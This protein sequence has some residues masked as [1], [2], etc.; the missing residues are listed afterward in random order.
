MA[1][2]NSAVNHNGKLRELLGASRPADDDNENFFDLSETAFNCLHENIAECKYF[3]FPFF[4]TPDFIDCDQKTLSLFR[5]NIRSLNKLDNF[6]NF[7]EFLTTLPFFPDIVCVS[8][9]RLKG[10]PLINVSIPGY[11]FLHSDS[12]TNAG[13]V[14]IYV[15]SKFQFT[16]DHELNLNVNGCEDIWLNVCLGNNTEKKITIGAVYR[17]PNTSTRN[18]EEISQALSNVM[19][20]I[21]MR[22]DVFYLLGDLNIDI[23]P[24]KVTPG[25]SIYIDSLNSFGSVPIV[26][27]R[28]RVSDTTSTIIDHIITNDTFRVIKPGVIRHDNKLSDHYV[29]FCSISGFSISP[30]KVNHHTFRD[31]SNLNVE[32]YCDEMYESVNKFLADLDDLTETKYNISFDSFISLVLKV[33]DNHSPLKKLSRKQ[34]KLMNKPWITK[35]IYV[36]IRHKQRMYRSHYI[37]GDDA[38]K[39]AYKIYSNKL[40]KIKATAKKLHY[41]N[42]LKKHA[43]NPKKTWELLR[44]LLPGNNSK[45][46]TLPEFVN[47][48]GNKI[49]DPHV[50]VEEFNEFFSNVGKN[51]A[52]NFDSTE[53]ETYRQ[54]LSKSVSSS[55]YMEPP[56]VNEVLNMINSLNLNKSVGHD[57]LLPYFLK[58][59]STILAPALCYFIDNAFRL[60]IF[61]QSCKTAKIVPLF[62]SGNT[63]SF[64]NY[65]P[66]SILTCFAKIFE[67]LIFRRLSTFFSKAFC[68]DENTIRISK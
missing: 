59:A 62:K 24:T 35:G 19:N 64:T 7:Y 45:S 38:M 50:I 41:E 26:T 68:I 57:N 67:K 29:I 37:C 30:L 31:K 63:Q 3:D 39:K 27:I 65:R 36:S 23:S 48:N 25:S 33:I 21:T 17:H 10:D 47:L 9:T 46:A 2:S 32:N 53:N 66:I 52:K 55:I 51:L 18:I 14:A 8:E 44:T 11:N 28:T 12:V 22:K 16:I 60:G 1:V 42:E 15:S 6:D 13:G 40:T 61:P 58:V 43:N 4:D 56:R 54:F 20:K 5:I 49:T 34:K